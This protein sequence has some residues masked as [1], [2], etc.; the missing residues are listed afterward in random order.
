MSTSGASLGP[1]GHSHPT[2][3]LGNKNFTDKSTVLKDLWR[4]LILGLNLQ[5]NQKLGCSWHVNGYPYITW[6]NKYFCTNCLHQIQS[7]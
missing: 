2:F 3:R 6:N 4:N 7:Q 1:I 5:A